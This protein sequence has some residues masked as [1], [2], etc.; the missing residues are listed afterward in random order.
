MIKIL[1]GGAM[2]LVV[3]IIGWQVIANAKQ[4]DKIHKHAIQI[5]RL[6]R[7]SEQQKKNE[8]QLIEILNRII[9]TPT[10]PPG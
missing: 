7:G 2:A 5:D 9:P 1:A 6:I 4:D 8:G 3:T 10:R